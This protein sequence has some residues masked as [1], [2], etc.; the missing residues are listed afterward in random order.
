MQED[1]SKPLPRPRDEGF[2]LAILAGHKLAVAYQRA[3]FIGKDK[4]APWVL[5][6]RPDVAARIDWLLDYRVKA[7]TKRFVRRQKKFDDLQ[8]KAVAELEK[9]AFSDVREVVQWDRKPVLSPDGEILTIA[10][11]IS[12][13]PSGQLSPAAAAAIKSVFNKG[14]AVRVELHDKQA[15]LL[16]ILK[17]TGAF[18]EDKP[19]PSPVTV[20]QVNVGGSA[21]EATRRI[22]F[23]LASLAA[24]DR[25]SQGPLIEGQPKVVGQ[26][27]K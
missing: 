6:H 25:R 15:A 10:D 11:Q 23:M 26:D 17:L 14:S 12:V 21:L 16:A 19:P 13:T 18:K 2:A 4:K 22:G 8:A 27:A 24:A 5:R 7:D 9:I 20:N 3:G 1:P